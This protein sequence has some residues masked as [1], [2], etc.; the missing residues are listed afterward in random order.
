MPIVH[1]NKC[2]THISPVFKRSLR[3]SV[4]FINVKTTPLINAVNP[5]EKPTQTKYR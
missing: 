3:I 1:T 5:V 4:P 2:K